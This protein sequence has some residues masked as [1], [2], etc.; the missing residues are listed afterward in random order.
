MANPPDFKELREKMKETNA[1]IAMDAQVPILPKL[2]KECEHCCNGETRQAYGYQ[3][4]TMF[5]IPWTPEDWACGSP[6]VDELQWRDVE[7]SLLT[8]KPLNNIPCTFLRKPS[9]EIERC[10]PEGK[11]FKAKEPA[12]S[13]LNC[14]WQHGHQGLGCSHPECECDDSGGKNWR[15]RISENPLDTS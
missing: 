3:I 7:T 14:F 13:C 5:F 12:K 10:G 6:K 4:G 15:P 1:D 11:W 9:D 8:G 2:C